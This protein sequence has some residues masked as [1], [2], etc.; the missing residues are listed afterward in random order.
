[1]VFIC[2]WGHRVRGHPLVTQPQAGVPTWPSSTLSHCG[3]L[4]VPPPTGAQHSCF[5]PSLLL[6]ATPAYNHSF[7]KPYSYP[8]DEVKERSTSRCLEFSISAEFGF[9]LRSRGWTPMC[10]FWLCH[11]AI[12]WHTFQKGQRYGSCNL[13]PKLLLAGNEGCCRNEDCSAPSCTPNCKGFMHM[14]WNYD[15]A[16]WEL[17]VNSASFFLHRELLPHTTS[18]LPSLGS[19][20]HWWN[21]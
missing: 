3:W 19:Q 13:P 12:A 15:Q 6:S 14:G 17:G 5:I 21:N 20:A 10:C 8:V 11:V 7:P 2:I 4:R 1:M 18:F 9:C 16:R